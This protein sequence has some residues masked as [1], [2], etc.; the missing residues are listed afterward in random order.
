LKNITPIQPTID[1]IKKYTGTYI[2]ALATMNSFDIVETVLN[3]LEI[4]QA[5]SVIISKEKVTK[6]KPDPEIYLTA[7]KNLQLSV[8]ECVGIEDS[9][10]GAK[11]V[12]SAG[13]RCGVIATSGTEE[14]DFLDLPINRFIYSLS[15]YESMM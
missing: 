15:D 11:A 12:L 6:P 3:V 14:K 8:H 7:L 2:F 1:F 9:P 13:M 10:I 4:K 5:F